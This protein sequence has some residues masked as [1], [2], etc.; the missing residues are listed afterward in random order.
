MV[1][2]EANEVGKVDGLGIIYQ[3]HAP[4]HKQILALNKKGVEHPSLVSPEETGLIRLAGL[5]NDWTRTSMAPIA[6]K[7]ENQILY[8]VSPFMHPLMAE[9]AVKFHASGN[10]PTLNRVFYEI[11][12]ETAKAE[13]GLEP[14]DR[15]A[16]IL[17][18]RGDYGLTP[19]MDDARFILGRITK[20]Y[21][22]KFNH[23]SIPFRNL[24]TDDIPKDKCRVNYLW[25]GRPEYCSNLNARYRYLDDDN[26][27]FG[28]LRKSAEGASQSADYSLSNVRDAVLIAIPGTLEELGLLGVN[29]NVS[30]RLPS[31]VL[32]ILR[33]Q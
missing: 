6:V 28:V 26:R 10:Y 5:S 20:K 31:K 19:E 2:Y 16:H 7:G 32:E 33:G 8:R 14:E 27:A 25:F 12:K 15:T 13:L 24:P 11:A 9:H 4:L 21:F 18:N 29:D 3:V 23:P 17:S 22:E 30:G 1:D